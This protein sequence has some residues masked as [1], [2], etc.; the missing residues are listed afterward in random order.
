MPGPERG[1]RGSAAEPG[2]RRNVEIRE[3]EGLLPPQRPSTRR[4]RR[5]TGEGVVCITRGLNIFP[6]G[7]H[8]FF[9]GEMAKPLG[10][11][12]ITPARARS[13]TVKKTSSRPACCTDHEVMPAASAPPAISLNMSARVGRRLTA[14]EPSGR[15]DASRGGRWKTAWPSNSRSR[16][17]PGRVADTKARAP[18]WPRECCRSSGGAQSRRHTPH[19][20]AGTYR[21]N[22]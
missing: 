16:T 17:A 15:G 4:V 21:C 2:P 3:E 13:T 11:P 1:A 19:E 18:P 9:Q 22:S 20:G 10:R 5:G 6:N 14:G 12:R 7:M 8:F